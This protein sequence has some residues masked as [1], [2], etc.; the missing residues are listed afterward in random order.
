M[1]FRIYAATNFFSALAAAIVFHM[2]HI[3]VQ[4]NPILFSEYLTVMCVNN[5][6]WHGSA[7]NLQ[8]YLLQ[9]KKT[10]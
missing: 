9:K 8:T 5:L 7:E 2:I 10:S 3:Y 6:L 1:A 4:S